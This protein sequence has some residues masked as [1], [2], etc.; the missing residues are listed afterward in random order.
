MQLKR[1]GKKR[2]RGKNLL[3]ALERRIG[4]RK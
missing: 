1:R 2:E 4:D 3:G